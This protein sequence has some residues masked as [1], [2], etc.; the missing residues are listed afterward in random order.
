MQLY[1]LIK[2]LLKQKSLEKMRD[3]KQVESN[4][5]LFKNTASLAYKTQTV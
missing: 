4:W 1:Q 2:R 5:T 3:F